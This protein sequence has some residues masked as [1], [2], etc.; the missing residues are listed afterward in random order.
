MKDIRYIIDVKVTESKNWLIPTVCY[1]DSE[2]K[3][4]F[5]T[6]INGDGGYEDY[7]PSH[8]WMQVYIP[9]EEWREHSNDSIFVGLK[10]ND[11]VFPDFQYTNIYGRT[12]ASD[13]FF[14]VFCEDMTQPDA[15]FP[16]SHVNS[17][18]DEF[19]IEARNSSGDIIGE[20]PIRLTLNT[21]DNHIDVAGLY[22]GT[23]EGRAFVGG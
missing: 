5:A 18:W 9:W 1:Q 2:G 22:S 8:R 23:G 7:N 14:D 16:I 10:V 21:T 20:L 17:F 3:R 12:A 15:G 19:V 4:T 11:N 6:A 13:M